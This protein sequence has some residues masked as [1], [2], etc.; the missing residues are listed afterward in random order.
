MNIWR[1]CRIEVAAYGEAAAFLLLRYPRSQEISLFNGFLL[2]YRVSYC[3]FD[4]IYNAE[5]LEGE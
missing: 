1:V 2:S 5:F 3:F 4:T